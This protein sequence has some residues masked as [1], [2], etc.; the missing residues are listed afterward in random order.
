MTLRAFAR[1]IA[2][3]FAGKPSAAP[4]AVVAMTNRIR[5][6][7]T[8]SLAAADLEARAEVLAALRDIDPL[9]LPAVPRVPFG[10]AVADVVTRH[11]QLAPNAAAVAKLYRDGP[12]FAM[13]RSVELNV[14]ERVQG[15][16]ERFI[17]EGTGRRP[18]IAEIARQSEDFTD[19]YA[20]T[21]LRTNLTTAQTEG[22]FA[23]VRD[24]NVR[25]A[26]PA[27]ELSVTRDRDV[28]RGRKE[29]T[30]ENHLA[31][32]GLI[33]GVDDPLWQKFSPPFGYRC[34]CRLK[35]KTVG[36]LKRLN[37]LREDGAVIRRIPRGIAA[38]ARHPNFERSRPPLV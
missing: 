13:A 37:L 24:P 23:Q 34:R 31:A 15:I 7:L 14:T 18:T 25:A 3:P 21:V 33:A 17:E 38:F 28:R 9:E 35:R 29:D 30:G 2:R 4:D 26:I 11:P 5:E 27:F 1:M 22:M 10:E 16:V 36:D 12:A 6:D 32:D 20:E 19:A 8:D